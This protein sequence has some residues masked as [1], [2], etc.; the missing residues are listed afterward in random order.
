MKDLLKDQKRPKPNYN[1]PEVKVNGIAEI[2]DKDGNLKRRLRISNATF[3]DP[4]KHTS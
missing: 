1:L 3:S 2:R 4:T